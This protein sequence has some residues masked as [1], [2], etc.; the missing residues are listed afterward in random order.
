MLTNS[1][2][3]KYKQE[4]ILYPI[5]VL[6]P[7]EVGYYN[8]CFKKQL[9]YLGADT[10][11]NRFAHVHLYYKWYY[12]L[13]RN[14]K[15]LDCIEGVL[16]PDILVHAST[17]FFKPPFDNQF[18]SWHQD[19]YFMDFNTPKY[20]TAWIA[21]TDSNE[22]N[23]CMQVV[24]KTHFHVY[25]HKQKKDSRNMLTTGLTVDKDINNDDIRNVELKAGEMS[26]HHVNLI[27]GSR[28]NISSGFRI[29]YAIRYISPEVKQKTFHY[30][31]VLVRGRDRYGHYKLLQNIPPDEI[32]KSAALQ[33]AAQEDY[34]KKRAKFYNIPK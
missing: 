29:G 9:D 8:S 18:I 6:G 25:P 12:D 26:L 7:K 17:L 15:I 33:Q 14:P 4:G 10:D 21:L 19:G 16:G 23:G 11:L 13:V 3:E 1:Q 20:V 24:A 31:A 2:S 32:P 30:G 34:L 22:N 28:P 27:H 5:P